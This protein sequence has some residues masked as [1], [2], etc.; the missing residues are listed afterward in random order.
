MRKITI[1]FILCFGHH[2]LFGNTL[3]E[4]QHVLER[5]DVNE[6]GLFLNSK[7]TTV[8]K[9][10]DVKR[11][12][13]K[14]RRIGSSLI[15]RK[16]KFVIIDELKS[17][18]YYA[19]TTSSFI[20]DILFKHD[21]AMVYY[22]LS[23]SDHKQEK[24]E[25]ILTLGLDS[26]P[27]NELYTTHNK[28]YRTNIQIQYEFPPFLELEYYGHF[29]YYG[30]VP[31]SLGNKMLKFVNNKDAGSLAQM[32]RTFNYEIK[33]Y[34]VC[35]LYML[36]QLGYHLT[37]EHRELMKLTQNTSTGIWVNVC[38]GCVFGRI[39]PLRYELYTKTLNEVFQK[40]QDKGYLK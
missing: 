13:I 28:Q 19:H 5:M 39:A 38:R 9:V 10:D 30:G 32:I 1:L 2:F 20:L 27:F 29:C 22:R 37:A 35:G 17:K 23:K 31:T 34:G 33:A 36:D 6:I 8:D 26:I 15:H 25:E 40:Y 4:L 24:I 14:D 16:W 11:I 7:T 21:S 12:R 18:S 3:S